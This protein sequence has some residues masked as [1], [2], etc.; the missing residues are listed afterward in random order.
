MVA[1]LM[2][3]RV[4]AKRAAAR[5]GGVMK[6]ADLRRKPN[7]L[8]IITD[9]EREVMHWPDGMGRGEPAGAPP[10]DGQRSALHA[11]A[12]QHRR[13]LVEPRDVLHRALSGAAR[14]EE[15]RRAATTTKDAVQRRTPMLPSRLPNLATVMAAAGYH[16]VLKG[17]LH[18]TRPVGYDPAT[19]RHYWSDADIAHLAE[20]YGFHGWNPPDM[21]DPMSLVRS[22][23]R[24]DQQRRPLRRRQRHGGGQARRRSTSS[25]A[26]AR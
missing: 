13:V 1:R 8:I 17:K 6:F 19:K 25:T 26:R 21:S 24:R 15:P 12:V 20:R 10:A 3:Q 2:M 9:Q 22:R 14:R 11:R 5:A 7:I 4:L 18:L 16:V 23:R